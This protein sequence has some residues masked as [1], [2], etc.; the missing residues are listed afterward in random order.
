MMRAGSGGIQRSYCK[1][2]E[3]DTRI[4]DSD[5]VIANFWR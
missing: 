1:H 3:I 2:S 5:A 4:A